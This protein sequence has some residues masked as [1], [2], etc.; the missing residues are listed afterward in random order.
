LEGAGA[1]TEQRPGGTLAQRELLA[2]ARHVLRS[3]NAFDFG[4]ELQEDLFVGEQGFAGEDCVPALVAPP[5]ERLDRAVM[6]AVVDRVGASV[7]RYQSKR[8]AQKDLAA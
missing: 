2:H 6:T 3:E 4:L 7:V 5:A 8:P 1:A